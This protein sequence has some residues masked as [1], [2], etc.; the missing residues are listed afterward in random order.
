MILACLVDIRCISSLDLKKK[1]QLLR[2]KSDL[3]LKNSDFGKNSKSWVEPLRGWVE[4]LHYAGKTGNSTADLSE[5]KVF[6]EKLGSNR[7]LQD[8][9]IGFDWL[10][11]FDLLAKHKGLAA[12]KTK[13]PA[14]S[15]LKKKGEKEEL[16]YQR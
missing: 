10:P 14:L 8:K 9:K 3:K 6:S 2:Q 13:S 1:D 7:L 12:K 5:Y 11:P 15:G 16:L 4:T